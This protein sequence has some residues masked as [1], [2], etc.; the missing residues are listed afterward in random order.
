MGDEIRPV[1]G[2]VSSLDCDAPPI[3]GDAPTIGGDVPPTGDDVPSLD[4]EVPSLDDEV[5]SLV[6]KVSS[7][8]GAVPL[9]GCVMAPMV[10]AINPLDH[11]KALMADMISSIVYAPPPKK[12]VVR[13]IDDTR[14]AMDDAISSTV[15][16]DESTCDMVQSTY[17]EAAVMI[18]IN[19]RTV[20]WYPTGDE[21]GGGCVSGVNRPRQGG[22]PLDMAACTIGYKR[23]TDDS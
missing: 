3:D 16:A 14:A 8:D 20:D 12:Y 10:Y 19:E 22:E 7:P 21:K 23:Q 9:I 1:G 5:P 15:G 4:D 18:S 13:S 6:G 2:A 11:R 17:D